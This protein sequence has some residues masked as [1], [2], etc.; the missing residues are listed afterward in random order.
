MFGRTLTPVQ[1]VEHV[2]EDVRQKGLSALLHYTEQFDGAK[3]TQETLRVPAGELEA[4]H[5]AADPAFLET[6]R[7]VR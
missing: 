5:A 3:L 6:L 4:A 1:V 7:R 2:C